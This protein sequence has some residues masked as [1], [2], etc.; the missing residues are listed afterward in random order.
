MDFQ[1]GMY[2]EATRIITGKP[3]KYPVLIAV[4]SAAPYEVAVYV[5]SDKMMKNGM[6]DYELALIKLR[7][8]IDQNNWPR[9]QDEMEVIDLPPWAGVMGAQ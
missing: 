3:V 4:E 2:A 8:C 5:A 7:A 9:C 6:S 1:L